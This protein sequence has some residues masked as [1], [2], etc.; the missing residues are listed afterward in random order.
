ERTLLRTI[1]T[2][3]NLT[4]AQKIA[5][6]KALYD[7]LEVAELTRREI[8]HR[9]REALGVLDTLSVRSEAT[10]RL[11]AYAGSLMGRNK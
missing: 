8:E 11:G 1:H 3:P 7:K 10:R 9:F 4:D 6:V 5:T 2:D